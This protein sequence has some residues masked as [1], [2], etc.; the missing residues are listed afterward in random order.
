MIAAIVIAASLAYLIGLGA[1]DAMLERSI[2][3][4]QVF[5]AVFW[6]LVLPGM[7]GAAAVRRLREPKRGELPPARTVRP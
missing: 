1:T 5:G 6:P 7:L 2:D 4:V 3:E